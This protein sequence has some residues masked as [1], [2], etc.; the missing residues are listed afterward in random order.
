VGIEIYPKDF[1]N[2]A[3]ITISSQDSRDILNDMGYPLPNNIYDK[4]HLNSTLKDT[5][6]LSESEI[7]VYVER[8]KE[9]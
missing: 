1:S 4:Q 5:Q 7:K 3:G 9:K 8:A 2:K 6:R